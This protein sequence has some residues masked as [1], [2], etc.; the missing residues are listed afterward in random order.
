[1]IYKN[2]QK[3]TFFLTYFYDHGTIV[4]STSQRWTSRTNSYRAI[5][6]DQNKYTYVTHKAYNYTNRFSKKEKQKIK[7]LVILFKRPKCSRQNIYQSEEVI[8][9]L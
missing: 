3:W 2:V 5:D 6:C 9:T 1:M 8:E 4:L 7:K